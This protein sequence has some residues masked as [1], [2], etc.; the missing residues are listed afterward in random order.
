VGVCQIDL[1]GFNI[2]IFV[3]HYHAEYDH[4]N[5]VYLGHRVIHALESAQWIKLTSRCRSLG[6]FFR[7]KFPHFRGIFLGKKQG[8]PPKKFQN[9]KD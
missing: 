2:H 5:D 3:S 7:G 1:Y 4:K 8:L 6:H 9:K